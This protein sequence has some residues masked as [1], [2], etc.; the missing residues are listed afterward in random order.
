MNLLKNHKLLITA[1]C[2]VSIPL[3]VYSVLSSQPPLPEVTTEQSPQQL[4]NVTTTILTAQTHFPIIKA[5][6]EVTSDETL[7]IVTQVAGEVVW[8][9]PDFKVGHLVKKGALLFRIDDSS[10]KVTLAN[11]KQSFAEARLALL[12]E[13]RKHKRAGKEWQK[14]G[15]NEKPSPLVLHQPQLDIA[16]A[17]YSAADEAV[18]EA[19]K[20]LERTSFY[21]PYDAVVD[22]VSLAKGSYV[23]TGLTLGQL[24]STR[25]AQIKVS[26]PETDWT[27]LPA[28][29][30]ATPIVVR[31]QSNEQHT[32][33]GIATTLSEFIDPKTRMRALTLH[34]DSPLEQDPSLLLGS[35]V[36]VEIKGKPYAHSFVVPSSSIT[37]DGFLWYVQNGTLQRIKPSILFYS[38]EG[39]GLAQGRLDKEISVVSTPLS[40]FVNGMTVAESIQGKEAT[41]GK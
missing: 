21:A 6:G 22:Q 4:I 12:Q 28:D 32:W 5:Y 30:N 41:N 31:S 35:Y 39:L 8:K 33:Q 23:S 29:L 14:S 3:T 26:L 27:Q 18:K 10:Y 2:V 24:K 11:A 17:R 36:Q 9:S 19:Q 1:I 40:Q 38:Q 34:V 16:N 25:F 37:A 20:N 7:S 13:Q 15:I